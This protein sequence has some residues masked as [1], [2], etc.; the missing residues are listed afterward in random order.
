MHCG[1]I[2]IPNVYVMSGEY[3]PQVPKR[4]QH[5]SRL[6]LADYIIYNN[7]NQLYMIKTKL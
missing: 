6:R 5:Q 1:I 4:I 3:T 7:Y 2:I